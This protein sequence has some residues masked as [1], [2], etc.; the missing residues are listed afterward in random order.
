MRF[1]W[2]TLEFI[3]SVLSALAGRVGNVPYEAWNTKDSHESAPLGTKLQQLAS[4]FP[5]SLVRAEPRV[6]TS[7]PTSGDRGNNHDSRSKAFKITLVRL[8][9]LIVGGNSNPVLDVRLWLQAAQLVALAMDGGIRNN[10]ALTVGPFLLRGG[11]EFGTGAGGGGGDSGPPGARATAGSFGVPEAPRPP[12][13]IPWGKVAKIASVVALGATAVAPAA[14]LTPI[15]GL[16]GFTAAGPAAASVAAAWQSY[17]GIVEAGSLFSMLTSI[18]MAGAAAGA[19]A[20]IL[21]VV[22][23][24]AVA[25]AGVIGTG[26]VRESLQDGSGGGNGFRFSVTVTILPLPTANA[27]CEPRIETPS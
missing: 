18:G 17:I 12:N 26:L 20:P 27:P 7:S 1:N 4:S 9:S 13:A 14:V 8:L 2:H 25:G 3:T 21:A 5:P 6:P 23:T 10:F 24:T 11:M 19:G 16:V 15:L 22:S